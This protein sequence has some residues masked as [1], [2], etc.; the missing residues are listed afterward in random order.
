A[1]GRP[2]ATLAPAAADIIAVFVVIA[3]PLDPLTAQAAFVAATVIVVVNVAVATPVRDGAGDAKPQQRTADE[4]CRAPATAGLGRLGGCGRKREDE[5]E[6]H[7]RMS[8]LPEH[9]DHHS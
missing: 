4:R 7:D 8:Q 2:P 9:G 5:R 3:G 1:V 6:G